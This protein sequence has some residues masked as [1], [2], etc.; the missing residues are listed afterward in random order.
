MRKLWM[1]LAAAALLVGCS[2]EEAHDANPAITI[3]AK[4]A[5]DAA[6]RTTI[7]EQ[8]GNYLARWTDEDRYNVTLVGVGNDNGSVCGI[9]ANKIYL[10]NDGETA[11]FDFE[12]SSNMTDDS[13][14]FVVVNARAFHGVNSTTV[15]LT[16]KPEQT[17]DWLGYYDAAAD[18]IASKQIQVERPTG[19]LNLH[20]TI[21]RLNA[22]LKLSFKHLELEE[23]DQV[24]SVT[25]AC[26]QPLAGRIAVE[27]A[28]LDG[29]TYPI[30]YTLEAGTESNSIKFNL[31][32]G[33]D[34]YLST[35]PATLKAGESYTITVVTKQGATYQKSATLP[36][37]LKLTAGDITAVTVNMSGITSSVSNN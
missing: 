31:Q 7:K 16:L 10:E 13:Y 9:A 29:V 14:T 36:S 5:F 11:T 12:M 24:A 35:L 28:D 17:Q 4:M 26:E 18:L 37:D 20:F 2:R 32:A 6:S 25:F 22:L 19:N 30:P 1:I 34:L 21:A 23:G 15:W 27:F 3:K 33:G 8:D